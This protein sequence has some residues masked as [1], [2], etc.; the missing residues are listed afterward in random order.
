M[1]A[2]KWRESYNE[3]LKGK[4]V[5][6]IPDNDT[7]GLEHMTGVE[8]SLNGNSASLKLL[9]LPG[10]KNKGDVSD[11]IAQFEHK[12]DAAERLSI[13]IEQAG[14]YEPPK[15]VTLEDIITN[16]SIFCENKLPKRETYLHPWLKESSI[17]LISGWRGVGKTFFAMAIADAVSNGKSFGPWRCDEAAP[18]LFLDGEMPPQD[19]IDRARDLKLD[20]DRDQPFIFYCDALANQHGIPRANLG[21]ESWRAKMKS[22]LITRKV[23]LWFIDNLASLAAGIDE[24]KKQDWDPINQWLLELRFAGISTIMLHHVNKDGGQ[25]GTSAR[26]DNLDV[27]LL[28]KPPHDYTPE[29]GARFIARFSKA[30]VK[31]SYLNLIADTEFKLS[32]DDDGSY[33]WTFGNIKQERKREILKMLDEGASYKT[34][35]DTLGLASKGYI[36]KIKNQA[37]KDGYLDKDNKLTQS[38]D[39]YVKDTTM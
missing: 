23:K 37:V 6:L 4:H 33:I 30:R 7:H 8:S 10:L 13:M 15:K 35:K 25:R 36:T 9:E 14:P 29:D 11:F 31:T 20:R 21:S 16:I 18:V 24:N 1:G 34:I 17:N 28:L 5:V 3:P 2:K 38:G 22:I 26:E 19:I 32:C 39:L 27:S 12:E